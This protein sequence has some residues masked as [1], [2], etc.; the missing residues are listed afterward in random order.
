[1]ER[2]CTV[3]FNPVFTWVT[4]MMFGL[5]TI[6]CLILL[7]ERLSPLI[8]ILIL[9]ALQVSILVTIYLKKYI[10]RLLT[11]IWSALLLLDGGLKLLYILFFY[12]QSSEKFVSSKIPE[13]IIEAAIGIFFF[14]Y[15]NHSITRKEIEVA[16]N[17][18]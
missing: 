13:K 6:Y 2:N 7:V 3:E 16:Q 17:V 8:L 10:S 15:V 5:I 14:I 12:L 1:M 9:I 4:Y 18:A 11:K